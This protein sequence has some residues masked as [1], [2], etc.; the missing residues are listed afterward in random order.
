[1]KEIAARTNI[2]NSLLR[3]RYHPKRR[4][5]AEVIVFNKSNKNLKLPQ[6]CKPISILSELGKE[7]EK[8]IG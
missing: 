3:V 4:K 2:A 8:A 6:S 1:M 7:V 5:I